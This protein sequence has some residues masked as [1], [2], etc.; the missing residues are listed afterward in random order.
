M[1]WRRVHGCSGEECTDTVEKSARMQWRRVHGEECT[2]ALENVSARMQWRRVHALRAT[3]RAVGLDE[4]SATISASA[5]SVAAN[6]ALA[7]SMDAPVDGDLV[8]RAANSQSSLEGEACSCSPVG[9]DRGSREGWR[10][11]GSTPREGGQER[12]GARAGPSE[13]W[14]CESMTT[15]D[16]AFVMSAPRHGCLQLELG[17]RD[18]VERVVW[19]WAP[20]SEWWWWSPRLGLDIART[21]AAG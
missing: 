20:E 5:F 6:L 17:S 3:V 21:G 13:G 1:Q 4:S 19:T 10:C 9:S 16:G 15:W 12:G 18:S 8:L 11:E 2:D 14:R 7:S